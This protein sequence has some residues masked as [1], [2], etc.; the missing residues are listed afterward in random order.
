MG[1]HLPLNLNDWIEAHRDELSPPVGAKTVWPDRDFIVTVVGGP[2]DRSDYHDDP[3]EEFFFQLKGDMTL[4]V[5]EDG[6]PRTP[7]IAGWRPARATARTDCRV[8]MRA[9]RQ[10]FAR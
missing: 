6:A 10:G 3:Y 4:K 1:L 8:P 2:N 9:R 5:I 7:I